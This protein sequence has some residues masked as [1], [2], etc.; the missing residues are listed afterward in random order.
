M[1]DGIE[2]HMSILL[3]IERRKESNSEQSKKA[4]GK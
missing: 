4:S 3:E 2:Q 1:E